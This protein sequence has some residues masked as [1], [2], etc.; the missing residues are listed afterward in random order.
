MFNTTNVSVPTAGFGFISA[1]VTEKR[2]P[3]DESVRLLKEMEEE[4]RKKV[5]ET[6]VVSDTHFECKIHR[7]LDVFSAQD[8]YVVIYSLNGHKRSV[9]IGI[10]SFDKPSPTDIA[11]AI[12]D[13][14]AE[15]ISNEMLK[16]AFKNMVAL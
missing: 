10:N 2:A 6:T 13:K 3:T 7:S 14:V 11:V 5:I 4:A 8:V 1:S 9:K 16:V 12:R 15:D